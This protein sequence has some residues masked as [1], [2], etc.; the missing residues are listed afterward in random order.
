MTEPAA[1][2]PIDALA[3]TYWDAF[4][5]TN[6]LFATTLGDARFDG[7]L[8]DPTPEGQAAEPQAS[9]G[10][11]LSSKEVSELPLNKRDFSQ[12]LLLAAGTATDANGAANF[13]QQFA[14]NG[15]R[16]STTVF[17]MD[18]IDTTDPEM[19]GST[20]SN[21][22]VDAIQEIRSLSGV[23]PAEIGHGAAGFTE[24]ITRAGTD[25]IHGSV[26][27][28]VRNAA[29]D[30]RNF[31]DRR[32][33]ASPG[34]IPPFVRNE[35]GFTVG[36]PVV[37]PGIFNGRQRTYFFGQYQG[38]RQVLGTTQVLSVPSLDERQGLDTT[39]FPGD[40]LQ[41]PISPEIAPVL[42]AYPAPNDPGGPFG[43]RTY[44]T[45]SKVATISDQFSVRIDHRISDQGQFF[46][47]FNFNQVD[48]PL[49]NPGQTA[50][51]PSFAVRFFDHQ[52][53]GGF[54]Y[55]R[56]VTPDFVSSTSVGFVRSTPVFPAV[57]L[58]QP[59]LVFADGIYESFNAPGGTQTGVYGCLFQVKQDFSLVRGAHNLKMGFE[60]R[61]NR[62]TTLWGLFLNGAYSFGGGTAYAPIEIPSASGLHDIHVG[63]PLPD[64]VSALLTGAAFS[65]TNAVAP[66]YFAQGTRMGDSAARRQAYNFYVQDSW[67]VSPRLTL[68]Y[69]LRYEVN[70]RIHEAKHRTQGTPIVG[71][72]GQPAYPWEPGVR[73][74]YLVNPQPVY[75]KDWRGF[76]PR[77]SLQWRATDRTVWRLGGAITTILTNLFQEN[78]MTGGFPN[79]FQSYVTTLP[80]AP[81]PFKNSVSTSGLPPIYSVEGTLMYE[82]MP[83]TAVP[84]NTELD[85]QR[86][87]NDLAAMT[88]GHQIQLLS[89]SAMS[90][91]FRNGYI[92][93]YTA[94]LEHS[95]GEVKLSAAYV[96]TV[97]IHL[98]S[99][100]MINGYP[101]AAPD[102]APFTYLGAGGQVTGGYGTSYL[103]TTRSHSTY[104][105][106][107]AAAEKTSA[108]R[109][110]GFQA[111]YT[112][113]KSLD[114]TSAVLAG[115][116]GASGPILQTG[117]QDPRDS[118]RDKGA[119]TFD[120]AHVF[121]LS[122]IQALPFDR[123]SFLHPLGRKLTS[124]WQLLNISTLMSGAPFTV[125]SGVQQT[126]AGAGG[127][128]RPDQIGQPSFSTNREVREDYFGEGSANG[129]YFSIPIGLA[130]GTGPNQG[131]FGNLG[132]STFRGPGFHNFDLSLI[133]DTTFGRRGNAEAATLQFRAEF[134]NVFNLVNFG[135]PLNVL[136]G[137]GFGIINKTTGTSRQIQLSLKLIF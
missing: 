83:T 30:A 110:I 6:P 70:S 92:G 89:A 4:L 109:W 10:E 119:S 99:L 87:Q 96:A 118:A 37:L 1:T 128:D 36:G 42:A 32:S 117:L 52:R 100:N 61:F 97:G 56:T 12:L 62:D 28:F 85:L 33:L 134:F 114:D 104:H 131:R 21:F 135:L 103:M 74:R 40:T 16:G 137:S 116:F 80:G 59:G 31:F 17:A 102:Y 93:S 123:V 88:P 91:D 65:Y 14:V 73:M 11:R 58:T 115:M 130:G 94:G 124:G 90:Q 29:F 106:L 69:G 15:Q 78:F 57:N 45:S 133:K 122:V 111:S 75:S 20:F 120:A 107:Q 7:C 84:P 76:G 132:R 2:R 43:P 49:T 105:A 18:G 79:S 35:F 63:D 5:E 24:I 127:A 125:Y 66:H 48:G 44:A 46:G 51:D 19:G 108:R 41:V 113:G 13:T 26:F 47:R 121:T 77:V 81:I 71:P 126:G 82:N 60:G 136:R 50:I 55:T 54:R 8:P 38:F 23:M 101:G 112:F 95:V 68:D 27:E 9:G 53:S 3:A 64:T 39:A 25:Q 67:K 22:N 34:R 129:D 98:G 72:D 86:F